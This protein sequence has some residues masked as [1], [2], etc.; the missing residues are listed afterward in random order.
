MYKD[1]F[2]GRCKHTGT[3]GNEEALLEG[4][5]VNKEKVND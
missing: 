1:V 4:A 3:Q 2:L 5:A